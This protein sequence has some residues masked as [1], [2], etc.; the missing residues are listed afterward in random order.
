[1]VLGGGSACDCPR[2]DGARVLFLPATGL[3]LQRSSI[4]PLTLWVCPRT[5]CFAYAL[6]HGGLHFLQT[7]LLADNI[8]YNCF[9]ECCYRDKHGFDS[10]INP[11]L[12]LGTKNKRCL[13]SQNA[14]NYVTMSALSTS[15]NEA[16]CCVSITTLLWSA[17]HLDAG[18]NWDKL[19]RRRRL[20]TERFTVRQVV[21]SWTKKAGRGF[22][23]P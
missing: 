17:F 20:G 7:T 21:A 14:S 1:M 12:L 3:Q 13:R 10:D 8:S 11:T 23:R 19:Q 6:Q 22:I 4:C 18:A 16:T 2:L 15:A 9:L 5:R